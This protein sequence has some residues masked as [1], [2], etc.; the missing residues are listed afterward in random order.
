MGVMLDVTCEMADLV[1]NEPNFDLYR[2]LMYTYAFA[3]DR[4]YPNTCSASMAF[5]TI[6]I[7][8]F[9]LMNDLH[10]AKLAPTPR[11]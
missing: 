2:T 6:F 11:N 4:S 8:N 7:L 9:L 10:G 5:M 3:I 1:S